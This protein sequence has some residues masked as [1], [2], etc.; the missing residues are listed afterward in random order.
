MA[1]LRDPRREKFAQ[2]LAANLAN[3]MKRAEAADE[4][5]K[6]AGYGGQSR[7]PNA[8]KRAQRGDVKARL[9][10]LMTP[11]IAESERQIAVDVEWAVERLAGIA[12]VELDEELI[13]A[14][15]VIGAIRLVAQIKD[16]LAPDK[17]EHSGRDG[18]PI[19]TADFTDIE[20]AKALAVFIARTRQANEQKAA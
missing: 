9:R 17:H 3:G 20:R 13:K 8:R 1:A 10:E 12:N 16:W 7:A 18:G 4:A 14:A 6:T 15:D 5:A 2:A 11:G 19:R